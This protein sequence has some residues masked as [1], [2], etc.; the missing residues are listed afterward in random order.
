MLEMEVS[1]AWTISVMRRM[2]AWVSVMTRALALSLAVISAPLGR[3]G[4]RSFV[5]CVALA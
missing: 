2:L 1:S 3:R 4:C 5:N